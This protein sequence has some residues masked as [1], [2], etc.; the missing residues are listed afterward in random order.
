MKTSIFIALPLF[1]TTTTAYF[2]TSNRI[3]AERDRFVTVQEYYNQIKCTKGCEQSCYNFMAYRWDEMSANCYE[4]IGNCSAKLAPTTLSFKTPSMLLDA[5][6]CCPSYDTYHA[7]VAVKFEVANQH[8]LKE[9]YVVWEYRMSRG[10][11]DFAP[12][13]WMTILQTRASQATIE[14]LLK[15]ISYQFRANLIDG[16]NPAERLLT[17]W[18][19]IEDPPMPYFGELVG[20]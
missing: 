18:I 6:V 20:L 19:D 13:P 10:I 4:C 5:S 12:S 8:I 7:T 3:D 17:N 2:L 16:I 9:S 15:E 1:F 14:G 11:D